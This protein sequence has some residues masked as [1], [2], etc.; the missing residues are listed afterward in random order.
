MGVSMEFS[1]A[2]LTGAPGPWTFTITLSWRPKMPQSWPSESL[3]VLTMTASVLAW[4]LIVI[5]DTR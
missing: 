3:L 2:I 4:V 5:H 1:R